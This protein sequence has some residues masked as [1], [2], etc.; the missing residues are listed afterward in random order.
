MSEFIPKPL[1]ETINVGN[2]VL[3]E[4]TMRDA[5]VLVALRTEP[6][7]S[8]YIHPT[9]PSLA[10]QEEWLSAYFRREDDY[11]FMCEDRAG[12]VL[13]T[14]RI[15]SVSEGFFEIGS[16]VFRLDA[17]AGAAVQALFGVYWFGFERLCKPEARF[18]VRVGNSR[19]W[20]FH[21]SCGATR[22]S[23]DS[24][25]FFYRL[26]RTAYLEAFTKYSRLLGVQPPRSQGE[27]RD[28]D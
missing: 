14:M 3:R 15:P 6:L 18:D 22:L 7:L 20:R 12:R 9:A 16:W 21:E 25:Y 24:Q 27:A 11:Y 17:P 1:T 5:A 19:V 13:G 26:S 4:V 10:A 28:A 23:S 2:A 8:R